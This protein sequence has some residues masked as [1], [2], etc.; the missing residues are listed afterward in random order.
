MSPLQVRTS[1]AR[2]FD[3]LIGAGKQ[4]RRNSEADRLCGFDVDGKLVLGRRLHWKVG[5]Q[6]GTRA[7][8]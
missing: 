7:Y 1:I 4:R 8:F 2:L 5:G 6:R 3:H